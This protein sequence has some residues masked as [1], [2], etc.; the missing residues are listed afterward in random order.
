VL[1][2]HPDTLVVEDDHAGPVAGGKAFTLTSGRARWAVVRSVSKSLGPD[3][4]LAI[5]AGDPETV[6]RVQGRQSV[7]AGW[8]STI[9]QDLVAKLWKDAGVARLLL[10]ADTAYTDRRERL[11]QALDRRGVRAFGRSGL[12]VWIP[13]VEESAAVT[14]LAALGW[15]VRAGERYRVRSG[16]AIRVTSAALRAGEVERLAADIAAAV[17][18][19]QPV[20]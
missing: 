11:I 1:A 13:V 3:L 5:L 4:R 7:G 20:A 9:L 15:A 12:N 16:P 2:R 17:Q 19:R 6:A 8:V 18:R 14:A 10:A